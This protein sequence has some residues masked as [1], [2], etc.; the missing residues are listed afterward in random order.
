MIIL[1][2]VFAPLGILLASYGF[3]YFKKIFILS[4]IYVILSY[5]FNIIGDYFPF[6]EI[7]NFISWFS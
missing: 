1:L 4:S 3:L 5:Y 6:F 7:E 2:F